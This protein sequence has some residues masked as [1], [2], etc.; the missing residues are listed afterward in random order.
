M[1]QYPKCPN[2]NY[3][4]SSIS[5]V[6]YRSFSTVSFIIGFNFAQSDKIV[7]KFTT[8]TGKATKAYICVQK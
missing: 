5:F 4:Q 2:Y 1:M 6:K 3:V 7:Q 8:I